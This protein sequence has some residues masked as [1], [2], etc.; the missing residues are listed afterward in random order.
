MERRGKRIYAA[1][2]LFWSCSIHITEYLREISFS[3]DIPEKMGNYMITARYTD[4]AIGKFVEYLKTL[5]NI[6]K[7]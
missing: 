3:S 5:L 1:Y 6:R 4:K 7:R 2:Y